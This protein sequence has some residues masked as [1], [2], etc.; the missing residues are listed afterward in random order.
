MTDIRAVGDFVLLWT[1]E[2]ETQ[3]PGGVIIPE[4]AREAPLVGTVA[5]A[6][7][8]TKTVLVGDL[9]AYSP[10]AGQPVEHEGEN[11]LALRETDILA[12]LEED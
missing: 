1:T 5:S 8:R 2:P 4:Q 3:S 6:G 9:V 11:Y 10:H 12:V 7:G